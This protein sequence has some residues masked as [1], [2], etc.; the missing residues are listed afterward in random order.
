M[1]SS[2]HRES[3]GEK[4]ENYWELG[5]DQLSS[6][7]ADL[8]TKSSH[9]DFLLP[10]NKSK[11]NVAFLQNSLPAVEEATSVGWN[12][13]LSHHPPTHLPTHPPSRSWPRRELP[14]AASLI[15]VS[16]VSHQTDYSLLHTNFRWKIWTRG[17]YNTRISDAQGLVLTIAPIVH[18]WTIYRYKSKLSKIHLHHISHIYYKFRFFTTTILRH[19]IYFF[20][21]HHL[22]PQHHKKYKKIKIKNHHYHRYV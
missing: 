19:I 21:C 6:F 10:L 16:F 12:V 15:A 17:F 2:E 4:K 22:H 1:I 8:V 5:A 9:Q 13:G 20:Q 3:W 18:I 11:L 7:T 14:T